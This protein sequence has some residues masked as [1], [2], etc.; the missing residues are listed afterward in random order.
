[1]SNNPMTSTPSDRE[2]TAER[3]VR[4]ARDAA[5]LRL[6]KQGLSIIALF[7]VG[8]V[9]LYACFA[10]FLFRVV[11]S[12]SGAVAVKEVTATGGIIR[13][14]T[15]VLV[16]RA[17]HVSTSPVA[18]L[19]HAFLPQSDTAR[20]VVLAGPFG[21]L[22]QSGSIATVNGHS[23]GSRIQGPLGT[24]GYLKDQYLI[25]CEVGNCTPGT[26]FVVSKNG[27][28]GQLMGAK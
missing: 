11:F 10:A 1:M 22:R 25:R 23:I 7:C 17:H 14:G 20:G 16:N 24:D 15:K 19:G 27:I 26:A 4:I 8:L 12:D 28:Y 13:P 6:L 21:V 18:R 5:N 2:P 3:Q 9:V